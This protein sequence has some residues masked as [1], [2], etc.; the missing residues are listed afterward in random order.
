[1]R[2]Q[3]IRKNE[4][5]KENDHDPSRGFPAGMKEEAQEKNRRP[6]DI[7]NSGHLKPAIRGTETPNPCRSYPKKQEPKKDEDGSNQC[8]PLSPKRESKTVPKKPRIA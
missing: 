8:S 1:M 4:E 7:P 6:P 3:R 5:E 2:S